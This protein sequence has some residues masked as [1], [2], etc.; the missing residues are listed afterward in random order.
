MKPSNSHSPHRRPTLDRIAPALAL[1][2]ALPLFGCVST[3]VHDQVVE[4]R[5]ILA[6]QKAA[7][8]QRIRALET[9][10]QSLDSERLDMFEELDS[11]QSTR[12]GLASRVAALEVREEQLEEGL[13]ARASRIENQSHLLAVQAEEV[14][15]LRCTYEG[16]VEDLEAEISQG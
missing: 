4:E 8:S 3:G 5:D 2:I 15:K 6:A 1:A 11:L 14:A 10:N 12:D 13:A 7:L 9:A 16:L